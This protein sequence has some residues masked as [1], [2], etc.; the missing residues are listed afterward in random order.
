MC[1]RLPV[2]CAL[3][4]APRVGDRHARPDARTCAAAP[5]RAFRMFPDKLWANGSNGTAAVRFGWLSGNSRRLGFGIGVVVP[6]PA[7]ERPTLTGDA[8]TTVEKHDR[9][10]KFSSSRRVNGNVLLRLYPARTARQLLNR[11][12]PS[13]LPR[14][15]RTFFVRD[16]YSRIR[17]KIGQRHRARDPCV[18]LREKR[19][20][21]DF[22]FFDAAVGTA[23]KS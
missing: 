21:S 12:A 11:A 3:G 17:P 10:P 18:R 15:R 6:G 20:R 14:P 9:V 2:P 5:P 19:C 4:L 7:P 13:S 8:G 22:F 16:T 23:G 1:V